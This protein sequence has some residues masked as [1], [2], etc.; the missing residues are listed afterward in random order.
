MQKFVN[1]SI[2]LATTEPILMKLKIDQIET[3]TNLFVEGIIQSILAYR[4]NFFVPTV[5]LGQAA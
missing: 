2:M 4:S 1:G 3:R 5:P